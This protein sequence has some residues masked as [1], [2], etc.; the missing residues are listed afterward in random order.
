MAQPRGFWALSLIKRYIKSSKIE[1]NIKYTPIRIFSIKIKKIT[2]NTSETTNISIYQ[3]LRD[4]EPKQLSYFIFIYKWS[5][6]LNIAILW[7]SFDMGVEVVWHRKKVWDAWKYQHTRIYR[8]WLKH[9]VLSTPLHPKATSN[10]HTENSY[11][12]HLQ[13]QKF[14]VIVVSVAEDKPW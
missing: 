8:K 14:C 3:C 2:Q 6:S 11:F 1:I 9:W 5:N 4:F 10:K 7:G 13:S 12:R